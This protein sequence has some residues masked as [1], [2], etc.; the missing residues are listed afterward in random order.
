M[1]EVPLLGDEAPMPP[2]ERIGRDD[3]VQFKQGFASHCLGFARQKSTLSVGE[4]DSFS[5]QSL[6]E[7]AVLG[8]EKF[9]DEQLMAMNPA[10]HHHQQKRQQR[11][12]RSHANILPRRLV[13]IYGQHA[14]YHD[15]A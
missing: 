14:S 13:Q 12:H 6:F 9:D 8:L 7:Q 3:G 10:R 5:L 11:R 4:P 2:H 15:D 1:R